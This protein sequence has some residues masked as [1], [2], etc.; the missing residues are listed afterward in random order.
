[1]TDFDSGDL[2]RV[3]DH[4]DVFEVVTTRWPRTAVI[5]NASRDCIGTSSVPFERLRPASEYSTV[6][7]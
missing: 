1:V 6:I 3:P 5:R 4:T 2:V 7:Q